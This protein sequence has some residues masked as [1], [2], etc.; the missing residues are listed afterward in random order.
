MSSSAKLA[1]LETDAMKA[2]AGAGRLRRCPAPKMEWNG[3]DLEAEAGHNQ[4]QRDI[5][6]RTRAPT[7]AIVVPDPIQVRAAADAVKVAEAEEQ[8]R[9]R[10]TAEEVILHRGF[11]AF[12]RA[13]GKCGQDVEPSQQ[14][15]ADEDN[16]QVLRRNNE[17]TA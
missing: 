16:Q 6:Q 4:I 10:H 3:G 2:A 15:E 14:F 17:Q 12:P 9:S 11:G 7:A 8:K 1:T 13:L 5:K